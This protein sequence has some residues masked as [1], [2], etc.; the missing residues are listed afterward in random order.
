MHEQWFNYK[1][2]SKNCFMW[3]IEN[4][5]GPIG[6]IRY[7][8]D[9][10][11]AFIDISIIPDF[12]H[13]GVGRHLLLQTIGLLIQDRPEVKIMVAEIRSDNSTSRM[14]FSSIGFRQT[15]SGGL[16]RWE[17]IITSY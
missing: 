16:E 13:Y 10:N 7:D 9:D 5:L 14:F 4:P 15:Q 12:R 8:I 1:I 17:A 6:Q 11:K 3:I 2:N